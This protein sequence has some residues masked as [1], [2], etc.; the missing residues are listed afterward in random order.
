MHGINQLVVI[1]AMTLRSSQGVL[2]GLYGEENCGGPQNYQ[3]N[4]YSNTCH[5][6]NSDFISFKLLERAK[7][8]DQRMRLYNGGSTGQGCLYGQFACY[9]VGNN[10]LAVGQCVNIPSTPA[11]FVESIG[12]DAFP[13]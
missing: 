11:N 13:C 5:E 1:L 3:I 8:P 9:G 12:S 10:G 4:I 6:G 7:S 2:I